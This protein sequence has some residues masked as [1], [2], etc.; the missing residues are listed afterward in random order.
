MRQSDNWVSV[1]HVHDRKGGK[2][3]ENL[4]SKCKYNEKKE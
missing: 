1:K 3:A 2:I 4:D